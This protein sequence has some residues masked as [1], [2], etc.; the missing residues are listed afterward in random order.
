M[1]RSGRTRC[2]SA[3]RRSRLCSQQGVKMS[4]DVV[5]APDVLLDLVVLALVLKADVD[6]LGARSQLPEPNMIL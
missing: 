4:E 3:P 6:L 1:I 5:L 2:Q